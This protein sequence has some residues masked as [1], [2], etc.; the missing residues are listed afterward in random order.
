MNPRDVVIP[1][2]CGLMMAEA[3][4]LHD[5]WMRA[6]D[7]RRREA[8]AHAFAAHGPSALGR[9]QRP[10]IGPPDPR[11]GAVPVAHPTAMAAADAPRMTTQL[12]YDVLSRTKT[13]ADGLVCVGGSD[14]LGTLRRTSGTSS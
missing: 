9:G 12:W 6:L 1:P 13:M 10:P 11:S 7:R 3:H 2:S 14:V 5:A 8:V 4:M